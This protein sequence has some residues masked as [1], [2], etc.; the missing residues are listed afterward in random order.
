[1][2]DSP[3][4]HQSMPVSIETQPLFREVGATD[5]LTEAEISG[6]ARRLGKLVMAEESVLRAHQRDAFEDIA[7]FFREG[8]RETYV[9][10]PTGTGK[11]V[12]FVEICKRLVEAAPTTEERSR[13]IVLEPTIDLADQTV[14]SVDP[15]TGKRRGFKGF[16]PELDVRAHHSQLSLRVRN[17]NLVEAEVL[18]TTYDT[19]RNLISTFV[20]AE[21]KSPE[22]WEQEIEAYKQQAKTSQQEY[23]SLR[24]E[25][26]KFLHDAYLAQEIVRTRTDAKTLL[27]G[28]ARENNLTEKERRSLQTIISI[29]RMDAPQKNV[30]QRLRLNMSLLLTER[31]KAGLE[32]IQASYEKGK[33]TR[34]AKQAAKKLGHQLPAETVD[35][36]ADLETTAGDT[37]DLETKALR[38]RDLNDYEEF[39]VK[40][41]RRH[42]KGKTL[43]EDDLLQVHDRRRLYEYDQQIRDHRARIIHANNRI[44]VIQHITVVRSG[45]GRFDLIVGD[46]FHRAIGTQ[47]WE[48]IRE[49]AS[50]KD[51]AILGLTAT[52]EYYDRS[53]EDY[54]GEK[55]HELTKE[56]AMK[57]E[58]INPLALFVHDTGMRFQHVGIDVAGDYDRYTLRQMRFSHERNMIGVGYAK[59]LSEHGYHGLMPAI[60]G[61]KGAHAKVLADLI[62][63]QEMVD[64]KTGEVRLMRAMCVLNDTKDRQA[65]YQALETGELD[66]LTFIDVIREGWDSDKA[67]ALINMRPTR[68]P[69][70]ATQRL[71]RIGRTSEGAPTS[72]V[73]DLFDGIEGEEEHREIPPVLAADV[74]KLD[75][76]EQGFVV[77]NQK[78]QG[79]L[80]LPILRARMPQLI[81]AHHSRF[82]RTLAEA[83]LIDGRGIGY[84]SAQ[85]RPTSTEWQTFEAL[86]KGLQGFLPKEI[87]LEA[88]E[89]E[90]PAVRAIQGRRGFGAL[91]LFNVHDVRALHKDKPE[92]N[93]WRLYIDEQGEQWITPEGCTRLL[94]K[95]FPGLQPEEVSDAVRQLEAETDRLFEKSV[96]RVRLLFGDDSRTRMGLTHL[97]KL[98]EITERLVPFLSRSR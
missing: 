28:D 57:R 16:A 43:T 45:V 53:L 91:P 50:R 10:M 74:F 14:G 48:A 59:L 85:S 15:S 31:M 66:W 7:R 23:E 80:L 1:M 83:Y 51:I 25:K 98:S 78:D 61:D 81:E 88:V 20:E 24:R 67:K 46:E 49:F 97:Y 76:I 22:E 3:E 37:P 79:N 12:V 71:G 5:S 4:T 18:V 72:I 94:S 63:Q 95:R 60:P 32:A 42:R 64:P 38:M 65:Y 6:I 47:T 82:V 77:G 35:G 93:P 86:Q 55:A 84:S 2:P 11:T 54:V 75:N 62:N 44:K 26:A 13:I 68:S 27:I 92:V 21:A 33:A 36:S 40:F 41:V 58:I 34:A 69:L 70:L 56:E 8:G 29:T 52:D 39:V 89:T 87:V 90:P 73:I 96:G 9:K 19:F 30:A 17:A